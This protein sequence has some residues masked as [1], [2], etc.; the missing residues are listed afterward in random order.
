M[1]FLT[2]FAI[3]SALS[4]ATAAPTPAPPETTP[5]HHPNQIF[6]RK[7]CGANWAYTGVSNLI[8]HAHIVSLLIRK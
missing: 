7:E 2:L 4:V 3:T 5:S 1:H 6:K 8:L